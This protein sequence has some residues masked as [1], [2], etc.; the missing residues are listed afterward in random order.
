[1]KIS[2]NDFILICLG[3]I[4]GT[5]EIFIE[6]EHRYSNEI[7]GILSLILSLWISIS[8]VGL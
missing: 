6:Q 5:Y 2:I 3:F 7:S 4:Y 8:Y 1:M